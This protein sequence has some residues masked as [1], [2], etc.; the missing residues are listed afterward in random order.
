MRLM[1]LLLLVFGGLSLWLEDGTA[2]NLNLIL[3]P[4]SPKHLLGT[5]WLGRDVLERLVH[6]AWPTLGTGILAALI[7]LSL[8]CLCLPPVLLG[9]RRWDGR[10][11]LMVDFFQAIPPLL[12]AILLAYFLE[13][14]RGGVLLALCF[15]GWT[16]AARVLRAQALE[17][18]QSEWFEA[19]VALGARNGELFLRHAWPNLVP[20]LG[21]LFPILVAQMILAE[22]TLAF[23]GLGSPDGLSWGAQIY[24]A[25]PYLGAEPELVL[26][27]SL[28]IALNVFAIGRVR[29]S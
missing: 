23:L 3:S 5:D 11:N 7:N 27:P 25:L 22:A 1:G 10:I 21:G 13:A 14:G 19:A 16:M 6:G 28:T 26:I 9:G 17:I 15:S 29:P 24:G 18:R 20:T 2:Q 8:A 12:A 4:A